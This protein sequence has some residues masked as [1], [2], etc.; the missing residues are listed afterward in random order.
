VIALSGHLVCIA[1]LALHVGRVS[2]Q[3]AAVVAAADSMPAAAAAAAAAASLAG[4]VADS[5]SASVSGV[6]RFLGGRRQKH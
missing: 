1:R 6:T 5:Y 4:C 2:L 3:L